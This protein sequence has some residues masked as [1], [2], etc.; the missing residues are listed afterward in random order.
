MGELLGGRWDG[1]QTCLGGEAKEKKKERKRSFFFE[2]EVGW[3]IFRYGGD[4]GGFLLE[5][6]IP[7]KAEVRA[8]KRRAERGTTRRAGGESRLLFLFLDFDLSI[9]EFFFLSRSLLDI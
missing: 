4:S 8:G 9:G 3:W 6:R 2:K 7:L 5:R 1:I